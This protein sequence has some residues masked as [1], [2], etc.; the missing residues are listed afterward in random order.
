MVSL[1]YTIQGGAGLHAR[2]VALIAAEAR[3][4]KS[5]V[6]VA[7]NGLETSAGDLMGLMALNAR[8]G[9]TLTLELNGPDEQQ[10]AEGFRRVLTF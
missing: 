8:K 1:T 4:W 7:C 6:H 10:A 9:D 3:A 2:P 5:S